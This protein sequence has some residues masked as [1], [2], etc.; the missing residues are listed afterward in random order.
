MTAMT[1]TRFSRLSDKA[2]SQATCTLVVPRGYKVVSGG[3]CVGATSGNLLW[4]S[5]PVVVGERYAWQADSTDAL[6]S[7][8]VQLEIAVVALYD[9]NDEWDVK[10][11]RAYAAASQAYQSA[12]AV[13]GEG[14][15]LTGG[16]AEICHTGS[17]APD[18]VKRASTSY[19]VNSYPDFAKRRWTASSY[20]H[21]SNDIHQLRVYAIGVRRVD[22]V[23][24]DTVC[25]SVSSGGGQQCDVSCVP[26]GGYV[27]VG[28]GAKV[29][30]EKEHFLLASFPSIDTSTRFEATSWRAHSSDHREQAT[31][32]TDRLRDRHQGRFVS[33]EGRRYLNRSLNPNAVDLSGH[34]SSVDWGNS[35]VKYVSRRNRHSV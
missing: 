32:H 26:A 24:L 17:S 30:V 34:S 27:L 29:D 21:L 12:S 10:V 4:R 6:D 2:E 7:K 33:G 28:G 15:S 22:G 23:L 11:F 13:A 5:Y 19:L 20:S 1:L 3:A 18:A 9:P 25:S 8:P 16:G 31:C 14:Y 35:H